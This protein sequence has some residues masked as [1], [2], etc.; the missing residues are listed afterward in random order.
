MPQLKRDQ[1]ERDARKT[2]ELAP[3]VEAAL[4]RKEWLEPLP[5]EPITPIAAYGQTVVASTQ[6]A[7]KPTHRIGNASGF[8]VPMEDPAE[9]EE[10]AAANQ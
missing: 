7:E 8:E 5:R 1:A 10:R 2:A 9:R 6:P 3:Y 4:K